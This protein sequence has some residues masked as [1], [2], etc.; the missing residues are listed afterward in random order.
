MRRRLRVAIVVGLLAGCG[1]DRL[2]PAT[3]STTTPPPATS[4]PPPVATAVPTTTALADSL[5][6][7]VPDLAGV[8]RVGYEEI[9]EDGAHVWGVAQVEPQD[10]VDRWLSGVQT[11]GWKLEG[12]GGNAG[13]R[14]GTGVLASRD[15]RLA[16]L[17]VS[18]PGGEVAFVD[19]CVWP[20]RPK[21]LSC[22]QGGGWFFGDE[23]FGTSSEFE[24]L[25]PDGS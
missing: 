16:R 24:G 23:F 10:A 22:P 4:A 14:A 1:A 15:R 3:T 8:I 25:L 9:H 2:V 17:S 5:F 11:N 21:D 12:A 20:T 18:G 19:L 6:Q 7:G 13:T